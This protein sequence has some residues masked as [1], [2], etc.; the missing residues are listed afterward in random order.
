MLIK[1]QKTVRLTPIYN[2]HLL[3]FKVSKKILNILFIPFIGR[4]VDGKNGFGTVTGDVS[5]RKS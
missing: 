5:S 4:M 1:E 3:F 2:R